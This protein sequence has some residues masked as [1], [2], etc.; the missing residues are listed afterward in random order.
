M[1]SR[2]SSIHK[3]FVGKQKQ[4]KKSTGKLTDQ[5]SSSLHISAMAMQQ[6][7]DKLRNQRHR[8]SMR[9]NYYKI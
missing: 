9:D 7:V 6:I 2:L 4:Q 1:E 5:S 8:Q 3:I